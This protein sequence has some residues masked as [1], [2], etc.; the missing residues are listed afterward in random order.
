MG[1]QSLRWNGL[2]KA[3]LDVDDDDDDDDIGL[4][5][6]YIMALSDMFPVTFMYL[7]RIGKAAYIISYGPKYRGHL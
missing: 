6:S 2:I 4:K 7:M 1:G 5:P 3:Y